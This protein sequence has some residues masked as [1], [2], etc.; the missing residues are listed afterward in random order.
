MAGGD[1]SCERMISVTT[2]KG[3]VNRAAEERTK[4]RTGSF[5]STPFL[6]GP[7]ENTSPCTTKPLVVTKKEELSLWLEMVFEL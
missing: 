1:Q 4:E 2:L 5:P 6:V 3:Y 7:V